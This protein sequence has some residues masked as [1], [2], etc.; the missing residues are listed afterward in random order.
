M[1]R[2]FFLF[3]KF[4]SL[5]DFS[6]A[7]SICVLYKNAVDD[8]GA[9]RRCVSFCPFIVLFSLSLREPFSAYIL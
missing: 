3:L 7:I 4:S 8:Q 5:S 9:Q 1:Y 2:V 6:L